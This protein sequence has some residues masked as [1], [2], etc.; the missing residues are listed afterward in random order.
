MFWFYFEL[1]MWFLWQLPQNLVALVMMPFL[2]KMRLVRFDLYCW[3]F[4]CEGMSGG[5]SLGNFIFLDPDAAKREATILH[6]YGHVIQSHILG[7]VYL[8][9][10][11]TSLLNACFHFTPCY[12]DF[13]CEK[14]A[15]TI[16]GLKVVKNQYGCYTY[17]PKEEN[18]EIKE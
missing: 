18:D 5:I 17:I 7:P 13:W 9:L 14:W 1:I 16:A 2:G 15:N 6:E 4:E 10:G 11:I 12:Y 8:L 3:A